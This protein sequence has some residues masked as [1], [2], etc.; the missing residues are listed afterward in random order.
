MITRFHFAYISNAAHRFFKTPLA[1]TSLFRGPI[2]SW[3]G[4]FTSR[5]G[6][7]DGWG[8][9]NEGGWVWQRWLP[10]GDW[11][12]GSDLDEASICELRGL[13]GGLTHILGAPFLNKNVMHSNRLRLMDRVWSDAL[14]IEVTRDTLDNARSI[15]RAE[16]QSGGPD[17]HGDGWWSVRPKLASQFAGKPDTLRAV[18]QVK[19]VANDIENDAGEIGR[20]RFLKVEYASLCEAPNTELDRIKQFLGDQGCKIDERLAVP[21]TFGVRTSK[22]MA[23]EDEAAMG[24]AL[25]QLG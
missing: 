21:D 23:D 17:K 24:E 8:A 6:H 13:T 22:P 10:D 25:R 9:P 15:L 20:S 12:D 19:G 1:A 5:F 14:F 11:R 18:A 4:D 7:I 16:R 3:Q 2:E